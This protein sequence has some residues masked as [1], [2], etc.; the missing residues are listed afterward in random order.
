MTQKTI[1][2]TTGREVSTSTAREY[3]R[4]AVVAAP[5][6]LAFV[7]LTYASYAIVAVIVLFGSPRAIKILK[8]KT[9]DILIVVTALIVLVS[10]VW[11][12]TPSDSARSAAL[13]ASLAVAYMLPLRWVLR[14]HPDRLLRFGRILVAIGVGLSAFSILEGVGIQVAGTEGTRLA[15]E[16]ANANFASA[17]LS[18]TASITVLLIARAVRPAGRVYYLVALTLQVYATLQFGSRAALAGIALATALALV[19]RWTRTTRPARAIVF[20]VMIAAFV[21]GWFPRALTEILSLVSEPLTRF[22]SL[23]RAQQTLVDAS[24][25]LVLWE[26]SAQAIDASPLI[27]WGPGTYGLLFNPLGIPAHAWGLEYVASVGFLGA[28]PVVAVIWMSYWT[29]SRDKNSRPPSALWIAV[30]AIALLPSLALS[31]HQWN[32]WAWA[33]FAIWSCASALDASESE[34]KNASSDLDDR[35][36]EASAQ[37]WRERPARMGSFR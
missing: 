20:V 34:R 12:G 8:A 33:V 21:A 4:L 6:P 36:E 30:T 1:A 25:R 35:S 37:R 32:V 24:G 2:T 3:L 18:T 13:G 19:A 22:D 15:V 9:L 27:G 29:S 7:N 16:F 23:G 10:P 5:L 14:D 26:G 31:T 11:H 17:A 28:I